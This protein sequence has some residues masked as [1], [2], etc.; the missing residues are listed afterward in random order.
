MT[1]ARKKELLPVLNGLLL[2]P[3]L[4]LIFHFHFNFY[5]L[6]GLIVIVPLFSHFFIWGIIPDKKKGNKS[7]SNKKKKINPSSK[8]PHNRL[9]SDYEILHLDLK[10][11]SAAELERLCYLYYKSKG[12]KAELTKKGADGGIDLTYYHPKNG[13]TAVQVKHYMHSKNQITV[14]KIRELDSAK[15]NYGCIFSEFITTSSFTKNAKEEAPR[16]MELNDINW[17]NIYVIPWMKQ[18]IKKQYKSS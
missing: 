18:E 4:W 5:Y 12:Y 15:K 13:K 14:E 6:F 10:N 17:F 2:L 8:I 11:I 3:G 9:L 7:S 1:K 16:S